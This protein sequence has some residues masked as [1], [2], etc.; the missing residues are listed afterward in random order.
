MLS[1]LVWIWQAIIIQSTFVFNPS[2]LANEKLKIPRK[3]WKT[4]FEVQFW[5]AMVIEIKYYNRDTFFLKPLVSD[6][7]FKVTTKVFNTACQQTVCNGHVFT[8]L[9]ASQ[10]RTCHI[11][12]Y[13]QLYWQRIRNWK[14]EW[15][16]LTL[17][18]QTHSYRQL[19]NF[20]IFQLKGDQSKN[21]LLD[22]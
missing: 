15:R 3:L 21:Y 14:V 13:T 4:M 2:K 11:S 6:I 1:N 7:H 17:T 19:P 20:A 9:S 10:S 5:T 8:Y 16:K 18:R 12:L 22:Y